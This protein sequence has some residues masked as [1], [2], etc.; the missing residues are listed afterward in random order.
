MVVE[1]PHAKSIHTQNIEI[2]KRKSL[3]LLELML[4]QSLKEYVVFAPDIMS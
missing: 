3:F 2:K 4:M 1:C